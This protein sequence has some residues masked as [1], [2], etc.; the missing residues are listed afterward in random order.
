M[1]QVPPRH[2][3]NIDLP[4]DI[5]REEY[6]AWAE[7][8]PRG[9]F[10]RIERE[11][12]QVSPERIA[13]A[14]VKMRV[15]AALDE[16]IRA[17]GVDCVAIGDGAT[18]EIGPNTDYEPDVTVNLGMDLDMESVVAP[19]PII[20]VEVTSPSSRASDTGVKLGGYFSVPSI[21]HYLIVSTKP[22][23]VILHSR[24]DRR[25]EMQVL[26]TGEI[27]LDPPGITVEIEKFFA[28]LPS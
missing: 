23:Q 6:R 12:V 27:T 7:R 18:V 8:Q 9:R 26:T 24:R 15:W 22:R 28:R 13:H 11:V 10:E 14:V 21:H 16:A 25:V 4:K 3:P 17:A 19:N 20:V 1:D 2:A 5:G